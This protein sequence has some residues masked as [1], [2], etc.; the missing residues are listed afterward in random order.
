MKPIRAAV[1]NRDVTWRRSCLAEAEAA[2]LG[3]ASPPLAP[4][5]GNRRSR[6]ARAFAFGSKGQAHIPQRAA[7]VTRASFATSQNDITLHS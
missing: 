4:V 6:R 3:R 1:L 2:G 7:P 5:P